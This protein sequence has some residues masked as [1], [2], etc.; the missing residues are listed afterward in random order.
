[1]SNVI[2]YTTKSCP[3]CKKTKDWLD[4]KEVDYKEVDVTDDEEA[5]IEMVEK[6]GQ[7]AVPVVDID[8]QIIVGFNESAM[9][10]ALGMSEGS[11]GYI[12]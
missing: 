10:A 4:E 8:G 11:K 1:M 5:Q 7:M 2:V 6:S 9:E 12:Q 3:W